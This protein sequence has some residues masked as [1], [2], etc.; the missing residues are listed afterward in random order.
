MVSLFVTS[1]FWD[2]ISPTSA[3]CECGQGKEDSSRSIW[4]GLGRVLGR[5]ESG[6]G[7]EWHSG[8]CGF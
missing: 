7:R 1:C 8:E 6:E 4:E 2:Q 3:V 5:E